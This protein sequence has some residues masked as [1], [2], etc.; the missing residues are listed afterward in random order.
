MVY[1]SLG[2]NVGNR[3]AYLQQAVALLRKSPL[4]AHM[5]CSIVLE[6]QAILPEHAPLDWHQPYLNMMVCAQTHASPPVFLEALQLIEQMLGRVPSLPKNSPRCIDLDI[7]LWDDLVL[8]TP[9]LQVPHP[10]LPQRPFMIHLMAMLHPQAIYPQIPNHPFCG[11]NFFEIAA[12][13]PDLPQCFL[14]SYALCPALVGVLNIT[15]DSFSDGGLYV[16]AEQAIAQVAALYQAGAVVVD[17][18]AQSTRPGAAM[19][20]PEAEYARLE[21]V[22]SGLYARRSDDA[23]PTL[24]LDSFSPEVICKVLEHYPMDWINVQG[25]IPDETLRVIAQHGCKIV[26]MHALSI[27]PQ[28]HVRLD[29]RQDPITLMQHWIEERVSHLLGC[30]FSEEAIIVDPGIGFGKSLYQNMALL[31]EVHRLKRSGIALLIGH[32]RKS[33]LNAFSARQASE[34]D[35]ETMAISEW[36]RRADVDYLRVHAVAEHQR[37]FV[38]QQAI[39]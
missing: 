9:I 19:L 29:D 39:A 27:P 3:L 21:P 34:R 22:L 26:S 12:L 6:T 30:G 23:L 18:G 35:L 10:A 38:A 16:Q 20:S 11:K 17:I 25:A 1:I 14:R 37:F 13:M 36:L 32:S 4:I 7:V 8:S 33:Y 5:K 31:R 28:V 2:S 24:S 15:P